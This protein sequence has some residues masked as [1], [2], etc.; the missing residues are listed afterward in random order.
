VGGAF[1]V[2]PSRPHFFD[3]RGNNG[4]DARTTKWAASG[5]AV[6]YAGTCRCRPYLVKTQGG[7]L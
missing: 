6:G 7:F 5:F 4:R 1:V 2:R 3:D